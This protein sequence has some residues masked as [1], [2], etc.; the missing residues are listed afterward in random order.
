LNYIAEMRAMG[1]TDFWV[2]AAQPVQYRDDVMLV[3]QAE[4]EAKAT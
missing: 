2:W 1:I 4:A 3:F